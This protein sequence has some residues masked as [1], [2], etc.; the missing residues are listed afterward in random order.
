MRRLLHAF[1]I[2]ETI[3]LRGLTDQVATYLC[4]RYSLPYSFPTE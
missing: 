1:D 4:R 2:R 3:I